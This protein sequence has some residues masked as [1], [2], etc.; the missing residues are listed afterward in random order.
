M[1]MKDVIVF[2]EQFYIVV[3]VGGIGILLGVLSLLLRYKEIKTIWARRLCLASDILNTSFVSLTVVGVLVVSLNLAIHLPDLARTNNIPK[4]VDLEPVLNKQE[5]IILKI[6]DLENKIPTS[7]IISE[8]INKLIQMNSQGDLYS[9]I[10]ELQRNGNLSKS[11]LEDAI[12]E[13]LGILLKFSFEPLEIKL[14]EQVQWEC[15]SN[16]D[17]DDLNCEP[18]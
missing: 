14:T 13:K 16:E 5:D 11:T 10:Q 6:N 2:F 15:K 1:E 8:Q 7:V 4:K 12:W 3:G 18:K 9:R 17:E